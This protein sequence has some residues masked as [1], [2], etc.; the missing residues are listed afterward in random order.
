MK[1]SVF[2]YLFVLVLT[3][4]LGCLSSCATK[5]RFAGQTE[6][7]IFHGGEKALKK[8]DYQDAVEYFEAQEERYPYG[9]YT[10]QEQ[11]DIIYAYYQNGDYASA[12]SSATRYIHLNPQSDAI[13]YANYMQA[14]SVFAQGRNFTENYFPVNPALRDLSPSVQAFNGFRTVVVQFPDSAYAADARQHMIY[15]R[16]MIADNNLQV[17][18]YYYTRQAYIAAL[19][20]ART[21]VLYYQQSPSVADALVLMV[22]CYERLGL[23][24]DAQMAR[25]LL[26][27]NYPGKK[28]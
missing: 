5:D 9:P 10:N 16:N 11:L 13:D 19:E 6:A 24:Q 26:A 8:G 3:A 15:I 7:Q 18:Q 28:F 21:V 14:L 1:K 23:L 4:S 17:G 27:V 2:R 22:Q 12:Q 25:E 20:R